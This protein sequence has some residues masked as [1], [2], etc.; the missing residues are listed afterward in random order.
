V[1]F[2]DSAPAGFSLEDGGL[3]L[4]VPKELPPGKMFFT[5]GPDAVAF[6]DRMERM[7]EATRRDAW[8]SLRRD[9]LRRRL[10]KLLA[11]FQFFEPA[12]FAEN[13]MAAPLA[14]LERTPQGLLGTLDA[15][16]TPDAGLD[17][18]GILDRARRA[19]AALDPAAPK[20]ERAFPAFARGRALRD[21]GRR[22]ETVAA[23]RA[24]LRIYPSHQNP[25]LMPLLE[26]LADA[27][28]GQEVFDT[29]NRYYA[30]RRLGAGVAAQLEA[31]RARVG[32]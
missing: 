17:V 12:L 31:L 19:E 5:L 9:A 1:Y 8:T 21:S 26:C 18:A 3:R 15:L 14:Q 30:G 32:R 7:D 13:G 2:T 23:F 4:R 28:Q 24:S 11:S 16:V 27:G 10:A 6:I 25:A 22:D 29:V 20:K